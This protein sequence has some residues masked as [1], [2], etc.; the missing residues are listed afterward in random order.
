MQIEVR[1]A[2]PE[3]MD[4]I[5]KIAADTNLLP[6][7][8]IPQK[9]INGITPEMT[10]CAFVDGKAATS[11]AAWPFHM[12]FNG[13]EAPVAG[14]S[15]VGTLPVFRRM[16]CLR[17]V[18]KRHFELLHEGGERPI[19]ILFASQAAIYQR[20]GYAV[21]STQ[22]SY[23]IE[24]G[25]IRFKSLNQLNGTGKLIQL[26]ENAVET[27]DRIYR[28]FSEGRT[29]Y[30]VRDKFKWE[31][32]VL[33]P[34]G[35]PGVVHDK[36]VYEEN[37]VPLGYVVYTV[38]PHFTER[39]LAQK[40]TIKDIAWLSVSA[41]YGIWDYFTRMDLARN[42]HW[43]QVPPDDPMPHLILEPSA[44]NVKS[45]RGLLA[46]IV[47]IEKAI[48]LRG[49]NEDGELFFKIAGDDMCPWNNGIWHLKI[50]DRKGSIEKTDSEP[51]ISM[52]INSLAVI[53]FGQLSTTRA[54]R[55][56]II[57]VVKEDALPGY[58]RLL[59]TDYMPFCCDII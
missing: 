7:D 5:R 15:I 13:I 48:P 11:Y 38:G 10:L 9:F 24:P 35:D 45:T 46:R 42:I 58:D 52:G 40:I 22:N 31:T 8:F 39:G 47:D 4:G 59:K 43:M 21:V 30:L 3:E 25:H 50:K 37:G 41:Y 51:E 23:Q 56:G 54:M 17:K 32:G 16:G 27:L 14:V 28:Q 36:I 57:D 55:M 33:N 19:S 18:H 34:P 29:G 2:K 49:Y 53:L 26:H 12:K 20:Y 1:P 44:L 6:P